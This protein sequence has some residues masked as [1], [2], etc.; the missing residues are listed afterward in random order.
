MGVYCI[1]SIALYLFNYIYYLSPAF[2]GFMAFF[3][4]ALR[5]SVYPFYGTDQ[6]RISIAGNLWA[7]KTGLGVEGNPLNRKG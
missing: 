1:I 7:D 3:P 6:P 4:A 5:H 2:E